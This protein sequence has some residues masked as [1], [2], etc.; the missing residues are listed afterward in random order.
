[1]YLHFPYLRFPSLQ[2]RTCVFQYLRF[3][4]PPLRH[5]CRG[6]RLGVTFSLL[7][8]Y[9]RRCSSRNGNRL[10]TTVSVKKQSRECY[11]RGREQEVA[12]DADTVT[13]RCTVPTA[14]AADVTTRGLEA[15]S[16][17]V[18]G[19]VATKPQPPVIYCE[20]GVSD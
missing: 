14:C 2:I 11:G 1:L 8:H 9:S 6:R 18:A 19:A 20:V 17:A 13:T 4:R 15:S 7:W 3:Q 10:H 12:N 5:P 16:T